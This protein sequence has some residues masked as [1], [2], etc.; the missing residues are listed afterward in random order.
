MERFHCTYEQMMNEPNEV[1]Q[2]NLMI[3]SLEAEEEIKQQ[4]MQKLKSRMK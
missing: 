1:I 4:K 3:M 2:T